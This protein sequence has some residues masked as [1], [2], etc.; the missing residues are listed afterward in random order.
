[1]RLAALRLSLYALIF[2]LLFIVLASLGQ[3]FLSNDFSISFDNAELD[4]FLLEVSD[5]SDFS[6][7]SGS[8][9][10]FINHDSRI[11]VPERFAS[12]RISQP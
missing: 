7:T 12:V 10:F 4:S 5:S 9:S 3:Q 11:K 6:Y 2:D 1:M 8:A